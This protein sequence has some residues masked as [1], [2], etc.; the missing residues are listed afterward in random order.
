MLKVDD[1]PSPVTFDVANRQLRGTRAGRSRSTAEAVARRIAATVARPDMQKGVLSLFDQAIVS[2]TSFAT[3]VIIGRLCSKSELGLFYLALTIVYFAKGIQ[4]QLVCAPYG[5]Y[6]HVRRD[7]AQALYSGSAILHQLS[8][9]A[10]AAALLLGALGLTAI[11]IGPAAL[12]PALWALLGAL[13]FLL[14]REVIRRL[15]MA[16]LHMTT[17]IAVDAVVAVL[18]IGGLVALAYFQRLT[19]PMAYGIMGAAC[20]AACCGWFMAKS[21]PLQFAWYDALADWRHNWSF[22]RWALVC[23]LIGFA[24]L[25]L[26]PWIVTAM[27]GSG[28]AGTLA[29][30]ITLV[31]TASMFVTGLS[32]F[33]APKAAMAFAQGGVPALRRVLHGGTLVYATVLGAFAL[34]IFASGDMLLVLVYGSDYAGYG[35][36]TGTLAAS[37]LTESIGLMAGIGLF[38]MKRPD[39]NLAADVCAL[40]VTLTVVLCLL[41]IMGLLGAAIGSLTGKVVSTSVRYGRLQRLLNSVQPA[42]AI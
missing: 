16:H 7:G 2:A 38:A 21:R 35:A 10:V 32:A 37:M 33:L 4:E 27:R 8:L 6:C 34:V 41:P 42:A 25:Y 3:S 22:A 13:P 31:G 9:S 12:E 11:G 20:A 14:L 36:V 17:A 5:V 23:H 29:A 15:S 18:Q 30:C 28:D 24:T 39:A 1:Q 26:T 40:L 19:V